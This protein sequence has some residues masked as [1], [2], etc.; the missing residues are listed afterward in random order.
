MTMLPQ[1]FASSSASLAE[2]AD[3]GL[4]QLR[5][6]AVEPTV[7][8][9]AMRAQVTLSHWLMAVVQAPAGHSYT[10]L[11]AAFPVGAGWPLAAFPRGYVLL[12][13]LDPRDLAVT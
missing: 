9:G 3:A 6:A 11:Q 4:G 12:G 8:L 7:G 2:P 10:D 5:I 1:A 13:Y